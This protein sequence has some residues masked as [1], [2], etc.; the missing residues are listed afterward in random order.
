MS[1]ALNEKNKVR[2]QQRPQIKEKNTKKMRYIYTKMKLLFLHP[3]SL[4][5]GV[6]SFYVPALGRF[7]K[8]KSKNKNNCGF[9]K[10]FVWTA[11]SEV[12]LKYVLSYF[13]S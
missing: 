5:S 3:L 8:N 10:R 9:H 2:L 11:A 7:K 12:C 6:I 1:V 13:F 4:K